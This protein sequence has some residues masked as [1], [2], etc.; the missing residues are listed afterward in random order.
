[1]T[2][3]YARTGPFCVTV[4]GMSNDDPARRRWGRMLADR[5]RELGLSQRELAEKIGVSKAT[6]TDHE[7]GE[8]GSL[9]P[10]NAAALERTLQWEAGSID[11]IMN[12]G[13]PT[14]AANASAQSTRVIDLVPGTQAIMD[15]LSLVSDPEERRRLTKRLIDFIRFERDQG[16]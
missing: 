3:A 9:H 12:G 8:R 1:M 13:D 10:S 15:E 6:I 16:W 4:T 5:R 14:L 2:C 7:R 11:R